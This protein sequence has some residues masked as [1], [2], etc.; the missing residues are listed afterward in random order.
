MKA[1]PGGL[2]E[3]ALIKSVEQG[4]GLDI[5]GARHLAVGFGSYHW[6]AE[7]AT[8]IRLFITVDDLDQKGFLGNARASAFERLQS[9]FD[10]ALALR[11]EGDLEFVVAPIPALTG[12]TVHRI[13]SR[14]TVAVFP[15]VDGTSRPFDETP[16]ATERA[17]LVQMLVRLHGATPLMA[18]IARPASLQL[19]ERGGLESALK[20]LDREWTGGPLSE[21]TRHLLAG[22]ANGVSSLLKTFDRV[23]TRVVTTGAKPVITHGE[24]HPANVV[25]VDK[26]L[27][28]VD[29]DTAA[30]APPERDLWMLDSGTGRELQL[31]EDASGR[32]VDPDA[33]ALFRIRWRLDDIAIFVGQLRSPHDKTA[34]TEHS[35]LSLAKSLAGLQGQA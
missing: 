28:L 25:R 30:M 9:A 10:A 6:V 18:S 3:G 29:W 35:L 12:E 15:F 8:G 11:T 26:R 22:Y 34:N 16:P 1:L 27:L 31:Y 17:E 20:E 14:Y 2:A 21:P 19:S 24:P 5:A 23:S 32:R 4:W 13:D 33:I 7:E